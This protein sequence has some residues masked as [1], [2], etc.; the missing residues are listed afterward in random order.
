MA[1]VA[2]VSMPAYGSEND[3]LRIN[4]VRVYQITSSLSTRLP[5]AHKEH[6]SDPGG[7][8]HQAQVASLIGGR[9]EDISLGATRFFISVNPNAWMSGGSVYYLPDICSFVGD[10]KI[11][12]FNSRTTSKGVLLLLERSFRGN[13]YVIAVNDFLV[14]STTDIVRIQ[15]DLWSESEPSQDHAEAL[16]RTVF[17]CRDP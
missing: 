14:P 2:I 7:K 15:E 5:A 17:D 16:L 13:Q 4:V 6:G 1:L 11:I 9:T 8:L 10:T 3:L 12:E